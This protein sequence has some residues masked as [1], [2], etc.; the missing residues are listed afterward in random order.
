VK[1]LALPS[2]SGAVSPAVGPPRVSPGR[3]LRFPGVMP[4]SARNAPVEPGGSESGSTAALGVTCRDESQETHLGID[5]LPNLVV[6]PTD[7]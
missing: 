6:I 3:L 1:P 5:T 2:A 4:D 7:D